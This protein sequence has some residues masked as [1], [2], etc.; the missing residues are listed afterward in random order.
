MAYHKFVKTTPNPRATKNNRGELVGPLLLFVW[1][2]GGGVGVGKVDVMAAINDEDNESDD[3]CGK[4]GGGGG[5][6]LYLE[7]HGT[8]QPTGDSV[9]TAGD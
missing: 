5:G 9:Q 8:L 7:S 3:I 2:G 4:G 1:G 6:S